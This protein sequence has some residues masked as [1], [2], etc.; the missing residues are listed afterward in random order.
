ME[1][2][3]RVIFQISPTKFIHTSDDKIVLLDSMKK[4]NFTLTDGYTKTSHCQTTA[5][6]YNNN[7]NNYKQAL[8]STGQEKP[9]MCIWPLN[10]YLLRRTE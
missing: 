8:N 1:R 10:M 5:N 6:R 2:F 3:I 7:I 4:L 9:H